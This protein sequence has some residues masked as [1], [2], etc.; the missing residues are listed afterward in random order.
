MRSNLVSISVRHSCAARRR[1]V[2]H[3]AQRAVRGERPHPRRPHGARHAPSN[4]T[5]PPA[6]SSAPPGYEIG[7][8][9]KRSSVSF[10]DELVTIKLD[11]IDDPESGTAAPRADGFAPPAGLHSPLDSPKQP[12]GRF[13]QVQGRL[14]A[15][16]EE[17]ARKLGL[18]EAQCMPES[19]IQQVQQGTLGGA[20]LRGGAG[21]GRRS[22]SLAPNGASVDAGSEHSHAPLIAASVSTGE[23]RAADGGWEQQRGSFSDCS[24]V[25]AREVFRP[26]TPHAPPPSLGALSARLDDICEAVAQLQTALPPPD[27]QAARGTTGRASPLLSREV[28]A[29]AAGQ[30]QL[31]AQLREIARAREAG[32][33]AGLRLVCAAS[34]AALAGMLFAKAVL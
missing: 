31:G 12:A 25:H 11:T 17:A 34:C 33:E 4:Y 5:D 22:T 29:L 15:A 20:T 8:T 21:P 27:S 1:A 2:H 14:R 32:G 26:P 10:E 18:E 9:L 3:L 7:V 19:Y 13:V 23:E 28:A 6:N 24:P 16:V 30:R